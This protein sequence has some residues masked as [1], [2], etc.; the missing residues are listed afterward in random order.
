[1]S[2]SEELIHL[3]ETYGAHNYHP[4]DVVVERAEGVWVWDV[5]GRKYLDCLSAYSALNQGHRHPKIIAAMIAQAGKVTLTSRAFH[6][7]QLGPF[8]KELAELCR[9]EMALPMN[10]GAEAV[11]TA[12]KAC[13]KW[14][15][16]VKG[17][18][19]G[20]AEIIVCS[21]NFHGRTTT[22]VGFSSEDQYRDGFGPFTPGF[23]MVPYG[24]I[25]AFERAI[26]PNTAGFLF[27]PIQ[28]EGGVIVP[29]EGY[30]RKTR[31][32]C[33]KHRILWIDDEIQTGFGRTGRLFCY[34][35]E[36]IQDPDVLILGK[37]LGGGLYP[38]SAI[39][40][41]KD[42][43]GVFNPGDHGS[44]FGG[45]PLACAIARA[46]IRVI[47]DEKLATRSDDLG[48]YFMDRLRALHSPHVREVRGRGLLIG[49]EIVSSSGP[50]RPF[51]E[52]LR[53]LGVLCKETHEQVIRFA[54]PLVIGGE[55]IDWILERVA[56]VLA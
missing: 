12:I 45:N 54:P 51:C 48:V 39:V 20:Q 11:E 35:W 19:E 28:G 36:G 2:R 16:K 13:R 14:G 38:V 24:D 31:E 18:A 53:D 29:P 47:V 15:Y 5:E 55:E 6:N 4:L 49:V 52:K 34:E 37:A 50:A 43:M 26:T 22:I 40:S 21:N 10:T 8:L 46:A 1:M 56:K 33:R 9:M 44:T 30:L 42:I 3:A 25:A 17:I 41:N 7:D 32:L 23:V 27:E